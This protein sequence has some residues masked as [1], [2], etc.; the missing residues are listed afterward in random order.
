MQDLKRNDINE[1]IH[2]TET[3]SQTWRPNLMDASG[4]GWRKEIVKEFGIHCYI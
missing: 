4:E 2:K 1:L 3:D